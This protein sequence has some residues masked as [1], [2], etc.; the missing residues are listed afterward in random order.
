MSDYSYRQE[1]RQRLSELRIHQGVSARDMSL[2]LGLSE[3]YINKVENGKV[4]PT[5]KTFFDICDYLDITP[6]EF[7]NTCEPFP[8]EINIVIEEMNKLKPEQRA[9]IISL[10]KDINQNR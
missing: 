4:L 7:F 5:M 1:F 3:G 6:L 10:M 2:S 9:R 8:M